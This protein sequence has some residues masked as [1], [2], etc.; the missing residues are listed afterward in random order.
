MKNQTKKII[1]KEF[2]IANQQEV[3]LIIKHIINNYKK[4][5]EKHKGLFGSISE[6]EEIDEYIQ[7]KKELSITRTDITLSNED[8]ITI[9]DCLHILTMEDGEILKTNYH[10]LVKEEGLE[11]IS[12]MDFI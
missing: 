12:L 10:Y 6:N 4:D 11:D 2:R 5:T 7:Y 3:D 1:S 8:T 9:F